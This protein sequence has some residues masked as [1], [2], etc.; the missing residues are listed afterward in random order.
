MRR[1]R[2][3]KV[4]QCNLEED[5]LPGRAGVDD[6]IAATAVSRFLL[7]VALLILCGSCGPPEGVTV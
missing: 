1:E 2:E 3:L 5:G 4:P 6:A 7:L